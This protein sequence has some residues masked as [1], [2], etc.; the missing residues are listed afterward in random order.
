MTN[1]YT[2]I[3]ACLNS[4]LST[5]AGLPP[6]QWPNV[7]Y[8]P[9]EGQ[10]FLRPTLMPAA[11]K[12]L[13]VSGEYL[14]AGMYQIDI[15]CPLNTGVYELTSLQDE[16][17]DLYASNK[18]ITLNNVNVFVQNIVPGKGTRADGWFVGFITIYYQCY[19]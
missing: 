5:L 6:V 10:T 18:T 15:F 12:L 13:T 2:N 11:G 9:Q 1:F 17:F 7:D 19:T 8:M 14:N 3:E 4:R 16:I